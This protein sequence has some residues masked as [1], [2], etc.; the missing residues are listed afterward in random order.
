MISDSTF[1]LL[2]CCFWFAAVVIFYTYMAYPL[3][4]YVRSRI[5]PKS[6]TQTAIEPEISII[7]AV[8]NGAA[9][10]RQRTDHLLALD[11]PE[12]KAEVVIVS[13]GSNDAT[14]EILLGYRDPRLKIIIC[15]EHRGKAAAL[16]SAMAHAI[17]EVLVFVDIRPT[18]NA[19]ALRYLLSNLSDPAVGCV[20]GRLLLCDENHDPATKAVGGWYW[21]YEQ[22]VRN[23]ESK[24]D[25]ALGVYGGFY[26]MRRHLARPLPEG[27]ILD[28]MLLPLGAT[29][30]GYRTVLD[31]RALAY[32]TWPKAVGGEFNRK[33]R[34]LAGNF[35]LVK[36]APWLLKR[37]NRL[38]WQLISHKLLRLVVPLLLL[39][40]FV[41]SFLL[42]ASSLYAFLF[43]LQG[44]FYGIAILGLAGY[45]PILQRV[46]GPPGAFVLLNSAAFV[47]FIKFIFC[48]QDLWKIWVQPAP[49]LRGADLSEHRG[50]GNE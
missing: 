36:L 11:Y 45:I 42:R 8:H 18:F 37:Q 5:H 44:L 22:W 24:V 21:R 40:V 19:D 1:I 27:A 20:T 34:T 46:A 41:S 7:L 9:L 26:A 33:V 43:I 29:Q 10:V 4:I 28:D 35:Q 49:V 14:N 32:D 12:R 3:W 38:R 16:N 15:P 47:G 30:Q 2:E 50:L 13:D 23:A 6:W 25:S 17:G 48:G 39:I 31:E